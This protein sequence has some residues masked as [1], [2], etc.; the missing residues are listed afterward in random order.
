MIIFLISGQVW[1]SAFLTEANSPHL[2]YE[3]TGRQIQPIIPGLVVVPITAVVGLIAAK[4]VF[5]RIVGFFVLCSGLGIAYFSFQVSRDWPPVIDPLVTNKVGRTGI[6]YAYQT[7]AYSAVSILPAIVIA[8]IG[9]IFTLRNF[10]SAKKK[11]AYDLPT[12][13]ASTLTPWQALDSGIDPTIDVEQSGTG[14]SA[15]SSFR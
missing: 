2:I 14:D 13:G 8:T 10:D 11:A 4:K 15:G 5:Q 7:N 1:A 6:D 9:L 3:F 12:T